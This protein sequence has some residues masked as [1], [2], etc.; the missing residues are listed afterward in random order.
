M[1]AARLIA[2][3]A[4]RPFSFDWSDPMT[5]RRTEH[6]SMGAPVLGLGAVVLWGLTPAATELAVRTADPLVVGALRSILA[7]PFLALLLLWLKQRPPSGAR[8]WGLATIAGL[9]GFVGF[10]VLFSF[11][12]NATSTAHAALII[13]AAPIVTGLIGFATRRDWPRRTWWAGAGLAFFGVAILIAGQDALGQSGSRASSLLGDLLCVAAMIAAAGGYVAG[14]RLSSDV[15]GWAAM[16]WSL[17]VASIILLPILL[18]SLTDPIATLRIVLGE[19][20]SLWPILF[21]TFGGTALGYALWFRALEV[22]G[23]AKIA[24][25]QFTQPLISLIVAVLALKEELSIDVFIA[26]GLILAGV[27]VTRRA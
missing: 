26:T 1:G 12:L 13:A 8:G 11:G 2:R 25:I 23:V 21:L 14:G 6:S 10:P 9:G 18:A 16:S 4:G 24:P 22:G 5:L 7:A 15:G 20:E 19:P 27:A 17:I 3:T